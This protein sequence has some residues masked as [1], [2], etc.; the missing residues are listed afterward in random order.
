MRIFGHRL[1]VGAWIGLTIVTLNLLGAILAPFIA[2]YG[3]AD[4]VGERVDGADTADGDTARAFGNL[5]VD[6]AGGHDRLV[7]AAE[8]RFV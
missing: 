4:P 3:E 2:P 1:S 8:V 6:V 5:I 7:T